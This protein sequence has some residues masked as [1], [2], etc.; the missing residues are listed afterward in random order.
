MTTKLTLSIEQEVI[1]KAKSY[2]QS[3]GR[4]LSELIENYLKTLATKEPVQEELSPRV[5]KLMGAV[6]LPKDYD[7]KKNLSEEIN[8][9]YGK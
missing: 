8:K 6:K 3:K 9:K 2:A 7:Y 4:S 5:K 1:K